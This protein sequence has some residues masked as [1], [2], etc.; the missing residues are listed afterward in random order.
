ML[1]FSDF[2]DSGSIYSTSNVDI[3]FDSFVTIRKGDDSDFISTLWPWPQNGLLHQLLASE[4][5]FLKGKL[6]PQRIS[7]K[8]SNEQ[9][10]SRWW[11]LKC[12]IF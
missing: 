4:V 8:F 2:W 5:E 1:D 9:S 6:A 12:S 10:S 7:H 11:Q 3:S